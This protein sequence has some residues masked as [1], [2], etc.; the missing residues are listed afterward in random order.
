M[1]NSG[2]DYLQAAVQK[3][4]ERVEFY[5]EFCAR[6]QN[7]VLSEWIVGYFFSVGIAFYAPSAQVL[8]LSSTAHIK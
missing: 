8:L 3:I 4:S 2:L 6:F 1:S 7:N 5:L